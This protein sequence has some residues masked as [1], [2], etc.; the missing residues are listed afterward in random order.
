MSI[1]TAAH[2]QSGIARLNARRLLLRLCEIKEA[3]QRVIDEGGDRNFFE[4]TR[5]C[6]GRAF[7]SFILSARNNMRPQK[8]QVTRLP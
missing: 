4:S 1:E 5:K 6:L 7:Y 2:T 8:G 3:Q